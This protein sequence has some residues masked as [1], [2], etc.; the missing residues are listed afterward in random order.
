M[1]SF[2]NKLLH[3]RKLVMFIMLVCIVVSVLLMPLTTVIYDL[4]EYVPPEAPSTVALRTMRKEYNE[5]LPNADVMIPAKSIPEALQ[6]KKRLEALPSVSAVIWLDDQGDPFVPLE[7]QDKKLV[8][9]FYKNGE[10]LYMVTTKPDYD[11]V[12]ALHELR[13]VCG[14][15]GAVRGNLVELANAR[16]STTRE[17]SKIVIFIIP[18]AL[19]ILILA[20]RSWFEPILFVFTI[21]IA[22]LL[23][24]GT[25]FMFG[26]IS[27]I[28]QSVGGVLQFAVSLDYTVF[29][30]S[31][32]GRLRQ[33]GMDIQTAIR[34]ATVAS[35]S[36]IAASAATTFF[37]FLALVL[38]RFK[39]GP[40]LG[41]VLAKGILFSLL[42]IVL[43]LPVLISYTYKLIDKTTHRSFMPS[44]KHLG[45]LTVKTR[46]FFTI[47]ALLIVVPVFM[48]QRS[49]YFVYGS[50]TGLPAGSRNALDDKKIKEEFGLNQG[51]VLMLP[52]GPFGDEERLVSEIEKIPDIISISGYTNL[53]GAELPPEIV[54]KA[55]IKR[56]LSKDYSRY[57][58]QAAILPES[59][60]TFT[61]AQDLREVVKKHYGDKAHLVGQCFSLLDMRSTIRSDE[62]IVNGLAIL[63]VAIIIMLTFRSISLPIVLVLVIELAIW[64]NLSVPYFANHPISYLG[65]LI[66]STV[67]LG[68]TVDYAILYTNHYLDNRRRLLPKKAAA[69]SITQTAGAIIPPALILAST[70]FILGIISTMGVVSELGTIL[71]RGALLT[72]FM[73]IFLLPGLFIL[74][75]RP[76][77]A[78]TKT[79]ELA[80]KGDRH[81]ESE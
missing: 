38:M 75:D 69:L 17:M 34:K 77:M 72:L 67:Q 61:L 60:R 62:P 4:S 14:P 19:L 73:V 21:G 46:W 36:S 57:F 70:G 81:V 79:R 42:S 28:T 58:I 24:M 52:R 64:I 12:K 25:N 30:L 35:F 3:H 6:N 10:A 11:L 40:D 59:P 32:F 80:R 31:R 45:R 8:E 53:V 48:A 33:E 18:V 47:L 55:Q 23:N 37:G 50:S 13:E 20:T 39:I 71:G 66:I 76:I 2:V 54:P 7:A 1:E 29:L 56:L 9:P 51:M 68:S 22:I 65:Y 15:D 41:V 16:S 26:S 44:F 5:E 74:L 78:L 43:F 63:A 49:N 27:F